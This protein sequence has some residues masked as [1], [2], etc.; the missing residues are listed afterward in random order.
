[1]KKPYRGKT[2]VDDGKKPEDKA[3]EFFVPRAPGIAPVLEGP[4]IYLMSG[5]QTAMVKMQE[6][7]SVTLIVGN[8]AVVVEHVEGDV[9]RAIATKLNEHTGQPYMRLFH[10]VDD[11]FVGWRC[12]NSS[13]VKT[14]D[15][16]GVY[17]FE[18]TAPRRKAKPAPPEP[19]PEPV[20]EPEPEPEPTPEPEIAPELEPE[21]VEPIE[22]DDADDAYLPPRIVEE[23]LPKII[24][25]VHDITSK[26]QPKKQAVERVVFRY[27]RTVDLDVDA[28]DWLTNRLLAHE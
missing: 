28:T 8:D 13:Q 1:L 9:F 2:C 3:C 25:A 11:T 18:L 7:A 16:K 20:E 6:G 14:E 10:E 24:A 17:A 21:P 12:G 5:K 4:P 23:D 26:G 22:T 19:E 27:T 15:E